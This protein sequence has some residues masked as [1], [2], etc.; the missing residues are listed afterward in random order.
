MSTPSY[1]AILT[2]RAAMCN[3]L[4]RDVNDLTARL[5]AAEAERDEAKQ[6]EDD[7][8]ALINNIDIQVSEALERMGKFPGKP[9]GFP[10][11]I[12]TIVR[13]AEAAEAE[14][15]RLREAIR[16]CQSFLHGLVGL[17]D[18]RIHNV[19]KAAL[20]EPTP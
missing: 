10:D 9:A 20:T 15:A 8:Q 7:A 3:A 17:D 11:R 5:A 16:E 12:D 2:D 6:G 19:I 1:E 13:I 18:H 4:Q 14:V